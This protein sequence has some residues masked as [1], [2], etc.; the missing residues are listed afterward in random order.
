MGEPQWFGEFLCLLLCN[1]LFREKGV[2]YISFFFFLSVKIKACIYIFVLVNKNKWTN[3]INSNKG[4]KMDRM[5]S[6][7]QNEQTLM[8]SP[9]LPLFAFGNGNPS[10]T[11]LDLLCVV[12]PASPSPCCD[13]LSLPW[14]K[15]CLPWSSLGQL[16]AESGP[17]HP[18][19]KLWGKQSRETQP[20]FE[21]P[22][23]WLRC[24]TE[25]RKA[26][27]LQTWPSGWQNPWKISWLQQRN[28]WKYVNG[29]WIW[30]LRKKVFNMKTQL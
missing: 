28:Y 15:L 5:G 30:V 11:T 9:L 21:T 14:T 7:P 29:D 4:Q 10:H 25:R 23:P 2:N 8:C 3:N 12:T 1:I 17:W 26:G 18:A 6:I 19:L 20:A 16:R 24:K 27:G 13:P 22:T